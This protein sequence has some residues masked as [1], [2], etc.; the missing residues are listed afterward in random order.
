ML[1]MSARCMFRSNLLILHTPTAQGL[2]DWLEVK[3]PIETR[4]DDLDVRVANNLARSSL[5]RRWQGSRPSLVFSASPLRD[6][7]PSGGKIYAG[8]KLS[9]L[10]NVEEL[11]RMDYAGLP[12]PKTVLL[13]PDLHLSGE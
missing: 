13:S 3:R 10:G 1:C 7:Q 9:E 2:S 4:A 12:I 6:Y 11:S 5:T 8:R